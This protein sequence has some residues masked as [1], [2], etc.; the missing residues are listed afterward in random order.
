MKVTKGHLLVGA[1]ALALTQTLSLWAPDSFGGPAYAATAAQAAP[2]ES[3]GGEGGEGGGENG[4]AP[5]SY[6]LNATDPGKW[7]Y[8]AAP[9]IDAYVKGVAAQYGQAASEGKTLAAAIDALLSDPSPATL[10]GARQ[11]WT[12]ARPAYLK[13][14]AFRF[15]DGPIEAVEGEINAWPMNEAYI[16]YTVDAP[17]GGI[18]NDPAAGVDAATLAGMNQKADEADVTTGW[19]AIEFLLWGQDLSAAGPGDRPYT[20]YLPGT[21]ATDKRRAYLKAVTQLLV[22]DLD[23]LAAAWNTADSGPYAAGFRALPTREAVGRIL[24]GIAILT[25]HELRSER[26]AVALDSGDQEDEHSCFS[27][28]THQDFVYDFAGIEAVYHGRYG[29]EDGP[30]LDG[31]IRRL[32]P[33]QADRIDGLMTDAAAKIAALGDP[34]DQVLAAP[35]DSSSRVA[36]EAAVQALG[37][38]ATELKAAGRT[39][40]VLVQVPGF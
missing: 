2:D 15:Y 39:L 22:T 6:A 7:A 29:N 30:G 25:G 4:G 23:G 5:S 11:A 8:D 24:N 16:D 34:W 12:S 10:A 33:A 19:H 37:D 18:V 35:P 27:D 1:G 38:L 9:E 20:D 21:P 17:Q 13:T 36:A 40:G 3:E 14:E 32:D 28:T 31:L 26:M